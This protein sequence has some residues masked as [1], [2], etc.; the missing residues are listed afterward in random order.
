MRVCKHG[1]KIVTVFVHVFNTVFAFIQC[2]LAFGLFCQ[3]EECVDVN[4]HWYVAVRV[5]AAR[6]SA[7]HGTYLY[8]LA[9]TCTI[10]QPSETVSCCMCKVGTSTF[11]NQ[12]TTATTTQPS[13]YTPTTYTVPAQ[14]QTKLTIASLP[15]SPSDPHRRALSSPPPSTTQS[16]WSRHPRRPGRRAA[17]PRRSS[18]DHRCFGSAGS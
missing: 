3:S 17:C 4:R 1:L 10:L 12:T 13:M 11:L 15:N 5:C 2:S 7:S 8:K 14:K 6:A 18:A 9:R 16:G